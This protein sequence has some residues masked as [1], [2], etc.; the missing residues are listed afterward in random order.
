MEYQ[1]L[2]N[3]IVGCEAEYTNKVEQAKKSYDEL[4]EKY[5]YSMRDKIVD[6]LKDVTEEQLYDWLHKAQK[7]KDISGKLF[8]LVQV[9]WAEAHKDE[10]KENAPESVQ[11]LAVDLMMLGL[12]R[13]LL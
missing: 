12:L 9:S 7:D 10:V 3:K 6:T 1:E 4:I 13:R 2:K 11:D 8:M 5:F